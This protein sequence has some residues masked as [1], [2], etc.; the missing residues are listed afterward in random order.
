MIYQVPFSADLADIVADELLRRYQ[1]NPFELAQ[2][3][4]ILPT[5]RACLSVKN[6][7]LNK[8]TGEAILLPQMTP[9]YELNIIDE[10]IPAAISDTE[11][12]LLLAKLCQAKPNIHTHDQALKMAISL[13][14]LLDATYQ[15]DLD[16]THLADLV[17]MEKYASHWQETVQFLDI[18]HS[19]WPKILR[20]RKQID[21]MDRSIRLIR[22]F[23]QKISTIKQPIFM[24]GFTQTFP[25]IN[26][27]IETVSQNKDNVI[28]EETFPNDKRNTAAYKTTVYP[29]EK[30]VLDALTKDSWVSQDFPAN[31]FENIR[32]INAATPSDE[33]LTIA[34]LLRQ[35]LETP[36]KTA[37]LV[38]TDRTLARQVI[39]QM[40]RWNILLDDSAGTPLNHTSIGLFFSLLADVGIMPD[41][42]HYLALFK[43]PLSA[44]KEIPGDFRKKVQNQE[45]LLREQRKSWQIDLNTDFTPWVKLFQNNTLISFQDILRQHID[46]AEKLATSADKTAAERLWQNDAGKQMFTFLSDLLE[47]ANLIGTIESQSYPEILKLLMQ[48]QSVRPRYGMHPRLDILGPIESRFHHADMCIIA[49]LNEGIFPPIPETGPWLNRP[50]RK[51]LGIPAPEEKTTELSMDFAHN[52]CSKEVYLTRSIK[53]DG[54]QTI[55]SRFIER[56]KAVAQI[57]HLQLPEYKAHLSELLDTPFVYDK[58][59]RPAPRPSVDARPNSLPVTQIEMWR[60][61]PYAIYARYVLKLY[62]LRPLED[63]SNNAEFG[64]LVHKII[65]TFITQYPKS[66]DRGLLIR[67]A[68]K[69]INESQLS[70][71]DKTL[72]NMK[73]TAIAEF[74]IQQQNFDLSLVKESACEQKITHT[75]NIDDISFTLY[76]TADRIDTLKDNTLRIID[77][78]TYHPPKKKEVMAGFSPQLSLEALLLS[79]TQQQPISNLSYWYLSNKKDASEVQTIVDNASELEDLIQKSK[80]G[81]FDMVRAFRSEKTPYEVCPIPSQAPTYDDYAHLARRQEWATTNEE[82]E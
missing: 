18:L 32:L 42:T 76:G 12:L 11:R 73:F 79:E 38:T 70:E 55:P 27:L 60:R 49:G 56:L 14:E 45:K 37:T 53:T 30:A 62:P 66:T 41:A 24:A 22:S 40:K 59:V 19:Q 9:I 20:E 17:Q 28:F 16:L 64:E 23:T 34:L 61:N 82:E 29:Q 31:T 68:Q 77:Y 10:N 54:T 4:L 44:D 72:L 7:F 46:L 39:A 5:K 33:A 78:K 43:H 67:T 74:I 47:Q 15:F 50:M 6:A 25:A 8:K 58:I 13:K 26:E 75:F 21:P 2:V 65:Q 51:K 80:N 48:Q 36:D 1:N 63:K 35:A 81:L 57:N 69:I 3:H 52:F 71:I